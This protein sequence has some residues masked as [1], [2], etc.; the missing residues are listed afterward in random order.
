MCTAVGEGLCYAAS[1]IT[2]AFAVGEGLCYA[3]GSMGC[4]ELFGVAESRTAQDDYVCDERT[5][6]PDGCCRYFAGRAGQK[7][8]VSV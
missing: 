6:A 8:P 5:A 3:A 1:S 4:A 2:Q 7:A